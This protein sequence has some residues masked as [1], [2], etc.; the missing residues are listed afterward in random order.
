MKYVKNLLF[1]YIL[2]SGSIAK[3]QL[4]RLEAGLGATQ[5]S[6]LE[7]QATTDLNV[8]LSIQK[9]QLKHKFFV[10]LKAF[11]NTHRSNVDRSK[12]TFIEPRNSNSST[13]SPNEELYSNYRGSEAEVGFLW[14]QKTSILPHFYPILSLYSKSIARKIS[15]K[16]SNY[17][18]EEKYALHGVNAGLAYKAQWKETSVELNGQIFVPLYQRITLYGELVGVPNSTMTAS[19]SPSYQTDLHLRYK[20][21]GLT[22]SYEIVNFGSPQGQ[23]SKSIKLR[24]VSL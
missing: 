18:E 16:N 5:I 6:W 20:R 24:D 7:S 14:N 11:G 22:L 12:Y 4:F 13:I 15:S 17:I 19:N 8:Q 1:L 10:A 9:K 3:A 23:S 21:V 2:F